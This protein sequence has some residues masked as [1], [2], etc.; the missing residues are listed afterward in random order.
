MD[1]QRD[2]Q[3]DLSAYIDGE[4]PPQRAEKVR[5]A[6]EQDPSLRAE[7]RQL[8][9]VRQLVG[10]LPVQHAPEDLAAR[11]RLAAGRAQQPSRW[12]RIGRFAAAAVVVGAISLAMV[13]AWPGGSDRTSQDQHVS[14]AVTLV[15]ISTADSAA[16][17]SFFVEHGLIT[18]NKQ[19]QGN[20]A[21]YLVDVPADLEPEVQRELTDRFAAQVRKDVDAGQALAYTE[22]DLA[23]RQVRDDQGPDAQP[24]AAN[25]TPAR[26]V[27]L[28]LFNVRRPSKDKEDEQEPQD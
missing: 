21:R 3:Q 16:L 15:E 6:L 4:L 20:Q 19:I 26:K 24:Q 7:V 27:R 1:T 23:N 8:R 13:F 11:V 9:S 18:R 14:A 28:Y 10:S 17:E 2:I 5:L 12:G 25:D 22:Q